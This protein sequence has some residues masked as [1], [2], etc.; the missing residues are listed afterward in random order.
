VEQD[1]I[2]FNVFPQD[3]WVTTIAEA[4]LYVKKDVFEIVQFLGKDLLSGVV[5]L[6]FKGYAKISILNELS[7]KVSFDSLQQLEPVPLII[8]NAP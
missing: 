7:V 5:G 3:N 8:L 1:G 4:Q 2:R 6:R